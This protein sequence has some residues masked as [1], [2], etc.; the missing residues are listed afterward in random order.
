MSKADRTPGASGSASEAAQEG[1][2]D[3]GP[4]FEMAMNRLEEILS[5]LESGELT[6]DVSLQLFEEGVGLSK[7]AT[8]LLN[9]AQR[10][11]EALTRAADGTLGTIPFTVD[12]EE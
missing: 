9:Q 11:V 12:E 1:A 7:R 2:A 5:Q 4:S 8:E 6:L 10:K 3:A